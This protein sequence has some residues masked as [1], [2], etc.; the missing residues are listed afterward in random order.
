MIDAQNI[1]NK[2]FEL[3]ITG[4]R[5]NNYRLMVNGLESL[6]ETVEHIPEVIELTPFVIELTPEEIELTPFVIEL[7]PFVIELTPFV[8]DITS[9]QH[10][11]NTLVF[12][13]FAQL[14]SRKTDLKR[15]KQNQIKLTLTTITQKKQRTANIG[16]RCTTLIKTK[17]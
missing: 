1:L 11:I 6:S 2:N 5:P 13:G 3:S 4:N 15:T 16:N 7:T 8:I 12:F 9:T 14:N 10:T 17:K